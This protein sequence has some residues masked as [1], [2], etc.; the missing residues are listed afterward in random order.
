MYLRADQRSAARTIADSGAPA[1][2]CRTYRP[3]SAP[4]PLRSSQ[5]SVAPE[6]T[7]SACERKARPEVVR[8]ANGRLRVSIVA[9]ESISMAVPKRFA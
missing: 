4:S 5:R 8:S 1:G 2:L 9:T 6:A 7:M 3:R